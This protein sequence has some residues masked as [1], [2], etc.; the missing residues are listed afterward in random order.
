MYFLSQVILLG[1]NDTKLSLLKYFR[2]VFFPSQQNAIIGKLGHD[3][4]SH[5]LTFK[6]GS[7]PKVTVIQANAC[8][9]KTQPILPLTP[10]IALCVGS[11]REK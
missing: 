1:C 9:S 3:L 2:V 6:D 8:I 4:G 10:L 7:L 11:M 5:G